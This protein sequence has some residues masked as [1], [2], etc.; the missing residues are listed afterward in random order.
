MPLIDCHVHAFDDSTAKIAVETLATNAGIP[1]YTNGTIPDTLE[2]MHK[3][4]VTRGMLLPIATK[5]HT[6]SALNNWAKDMQDEHEEFLSFGSIYPKADSA[7]KELEHIK[8]LGLHGVK[9]HGTY[10]NFTMQDESLYPLFG[11]MAELQ[12][13][14]L[15]HMGYFY[16]DTLIADPVDVAKVSDLYPNLI[17]IAAHMGGLEI[18]DD[19]EKYLVGRDR[20]YFDTAY[21]GFWK[22]DKQKI[23]S[24][25]QKHGADKVLF[26]SDTP[27][28][29][30]EIETA[31]VEDL[32]L[33]EE[34]KEF[35][36]YKNAAKLFGVTDI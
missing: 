10:Q 25:I 32:G 5:P 19:A 28:S 11:I 12:L 24:M 14:V 3:W 29:T 18:L 6:Q 17:I 4:G 15:I 13:P 20:I 30:P 8:E 35:I 26:S 36:Y 2:K 7:A 34:E 31:F 22:S 16:G 33:S 1:Y 23:A 27:W 21:A 9:L